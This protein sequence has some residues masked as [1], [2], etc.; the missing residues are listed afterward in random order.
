MK[1]LMLVWMM[2]LCL[3]PLGGMGRGRSIGT[4]V[5]GHG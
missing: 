4:S 3:V 1:R 5:P 2:I